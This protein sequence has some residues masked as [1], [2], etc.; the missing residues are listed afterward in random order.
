MRLLVHDNIKPH[1]L[2][3]LVLYR[4]KNVD[5]C[6]AVATDNALITPIITAADQKGL[7]TISAQVKEL[8]QNAR[9]GKLAPHQYQVG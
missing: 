2:I 5:I 1:R 8:A 6:V 9:L 4:H 7:A 3:F